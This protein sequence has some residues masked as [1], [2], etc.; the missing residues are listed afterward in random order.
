MDTKKRSFFAIQ[1]YGRFCHPPKK[2]IKF[3][4]LIVS[5]LSD[6]LVQTGSCETVFRRIPKNERL[7]EFFRVVFCGQLTRA[8]SREHKRARVTHGDKSGPVAGLVREARPDG[9]RGR[10]WR[11]VAGRGGGGG[12]SEFMDFNRVSIRTDL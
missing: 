7:F 6:C 3:L 10:R 11:L 8:D 4:I 5:V 2:M 9:K 1:I 12:I